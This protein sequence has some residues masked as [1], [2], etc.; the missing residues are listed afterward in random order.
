MEFPFK[1]WIRFDS[2]ESETDK[3]LIDPVQLRATYLANLAQF[4]K[5]LKEGC[6]RHRI[7]LV[8]VTTDNPYAEVLAHYLAQRM[9][10][11]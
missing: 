2:L 1:Q 7:D 10:S 6:H 3:R 11:G 9:K 4:R 5:A 8:P